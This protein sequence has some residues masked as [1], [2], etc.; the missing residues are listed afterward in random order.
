MLSIGALSMLLIPVP[1]S[2]ADARVTRIVIASRQP[3]AGGA[4]FGS[5]GPY[6]SQ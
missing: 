4:S 2:G 3:I 1:A 5:V 6:E